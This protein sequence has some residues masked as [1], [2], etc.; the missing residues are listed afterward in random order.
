[1]YAT[2]GAVYATQGGVYATQGAVY[3]TQGGVYA[4]QGSV[5]ATQGA[6]YATQGAVSVYYIGVS[7]CYTGCSVC[8]TGCSQCMLHRGQCMLHRVQCMLH[9]VQSVYAT[10]GSVCPHQRHAALLAPGARTGEI[11]HH[12]RH[13]ATIGH[14]SVTLRGL[15]T[16][17]PLAPVC[18]ALAW[19]RVLNNQLPIHHWNLAM[20]QMH[21]L[22]GV[23]VVV[24]AICEV[25]LT[26]PRTTKILS[27]VCK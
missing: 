7:V 23:D 22:S 17:A 1:V 3:A 12:G 2:Q 6:V 26:V 27:I 11:L 4:T 8:Y 14:W 13:L 15:V 21:R 24:T 18:T 16:S 9:R 10:Y 5:Y 19:G 25:R 20:V